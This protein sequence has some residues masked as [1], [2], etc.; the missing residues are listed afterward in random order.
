MSTNNDAI[1][2]SQLLSKVCLFDNMRREEVLCLLKL[3]NKLTFQA[4]HYV[5]RENDMGAAL[6]ILAAGT[7]EVRKHAGQNKSLV[8]ATLSPGATF[9][10]IGLVRDHKRT[11]SVY[12]REACMVLTMEARSLLDMPEISSKL[13]MNLSRLLADR[14]VNA[15]EMLLAR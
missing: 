10:E 15:N 8:L 7:V 6:Y 3:M 11:A 12:A 9:G 13:Y 5:F 1:V 2:L 4:G 14:L